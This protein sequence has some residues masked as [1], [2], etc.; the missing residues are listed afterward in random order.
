MDLRKYTPSESERILLDT[1]M[2]KNNICFSGC[3]IFQHTKHRFGFLRTIYGDCKVCFVQFWSTRLLVDDVYREYTSK[4]TKPIFNP[5]PNRIRPFLP[6]LEIIDG[7]QDGWEKKVVA[8]SKSDSKKTLVVLE[9]IVWYQAAKRHYK[10][11][12]Q[13]L[14][15][16]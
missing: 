13:I 10:R 9:D 7:E 2:E 12:F 4:I 1:F 16:F 15:A 3:Q 11:I 6:R 8:Y 5:D 14:E